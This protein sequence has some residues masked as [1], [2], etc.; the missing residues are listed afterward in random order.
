MAHADRS[1]AIDLA[2]PAQFASVIVEVAA[3]ETVE[4][5]VA[6]IQEAVERLEVVKQGDVCP[7]G[8]LSPTGG[9]PALS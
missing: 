7:T 6:R 8:S 1:L 3:G 2:P 4:D 9:Q 5:V